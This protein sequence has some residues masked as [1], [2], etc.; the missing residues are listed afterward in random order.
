VGALGGPNQGTHQGCPIRIKLR[1]T[2]AGTFG[3]MR[4]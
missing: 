3:I 2:R 1:N 4:T